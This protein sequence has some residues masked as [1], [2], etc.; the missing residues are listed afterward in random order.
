MS[1][2]KPVNE[3][4]QDDEEQLSEPEPLPSAVMTEPESEPSSGDS[5]LSLEDEL[6]R[7]LARFMEDDQQ[8]QPVESETSDDPFSTSDKPD[9]DL[10][11]PDALE[12][13]FEDTD[14]ASEQDN[15]EQKNK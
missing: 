14:E 10:S 11:S 6:E 7:D 4:P 3:Q 1:V 13:H 8:Q 2:E 9:F 5:S 12:I 15:S